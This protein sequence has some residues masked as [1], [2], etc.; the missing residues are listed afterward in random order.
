MNATT[1][2][3][4][5]PE[6]LAIHVRLAGQDDIA[7]VSNS[8]LKSYRDADAVAGCPNRVYFPWQ[9]RVLER[10]IPRAALLVAC[11]DS[12][13]SKIAGWCCYERQSGAI[14]LH[15]VYVKGKHRRLGLAR[16][17]I[18]MVRDAEAVPTVFFT[19]RTPVVDRLPLGPEWIYHPFLAHDEGAA[20]APPAAPAPPPL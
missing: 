14:V 2:H 20:A 19:H 13:P 6:P 11:L 3:A 8:W 15:Y 12:D 17:M 9:H 4:G 5:P 1:Y 18:E 16:Q 7:F 10:L